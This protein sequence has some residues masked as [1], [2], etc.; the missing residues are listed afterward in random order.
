VS[1]RRQRQLAA[2]LAGVWTG[3]MVGIGFVAAPALFSTL[4]RGD[5]GR[6][7]NRLFELDAYVG[8]AFGACLLILALRRSHEPLPAGA[9]R[10][11]AEMMLALGALFCIVAG[12]FAVLPMMEAAR[13]GTPGPSFAVLHGV[14][15]GF[16]FV[17]VIA[18]AVLAWRCAGVPAQAVKAAEPTS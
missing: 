14:A 4:A 12:Y 16:F 13:A 18:V 5:A 10:F 9:S 7:A 3:L 15:A 17:K 6:V 2:W 11:S 1:A 8:L